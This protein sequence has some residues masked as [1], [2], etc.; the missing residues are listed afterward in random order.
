MI[1]LPEGQLALEAGQESQYLKCSI[2]ITLNKLM[3]KILILCSIVLPQLKVPSGQIGSTWEW[4]HWIGIEKNINSYRLLIIFL[5]FD[6]EYLRRFQ[7]SEPPNTKHNLQPPASSAHGL[8]RILSFYWLAHFYFIKKSAKVLHYF[9]L[10]CI[11]C[12]SFFKYFS[13]QAII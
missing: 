3:Y 7:S 4:Y 10:D 13:S 5:N 12:K 6:L 1:F 11:G 2:C 9:G 8:Y